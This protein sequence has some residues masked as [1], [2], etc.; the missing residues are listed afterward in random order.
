MKSSLQT[1]FR[2]KINFNLKSKRNLVDK[3]MRHYVNQSVKILSDIR[4]VLGQTDFK[5]AAKG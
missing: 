3:N 1:K 5:T 4:A 2:M